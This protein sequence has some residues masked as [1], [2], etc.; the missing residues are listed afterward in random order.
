ENHRKEG[1]RLRIFNE[2]T[3]PFR[4]IDL[5][6]MIARMTGAPIAHVDNPRREAD[7]NDLFVENRGLVG[8][9]LKPITLEEGLIREIAEIVRKY[10]SNCDR[11]KIPCVPRW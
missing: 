9:G 2:M 6:N 3:E 5:A 7:S 10:A 1:E 4:L 11:S 8:L